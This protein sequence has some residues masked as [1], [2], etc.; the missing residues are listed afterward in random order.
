VVSEDTASQAKYG[1]REYPD[2]GPFI[3]SYGEAQDWCN[4]VT[5][6]YGDLR[7]GYTVTI[8]ANRSLNHMRWCM[9]R[10]VSDLVELIF[11]SSSR[12]GTGLGLNANFYIESVGMTMDSNRILTAAYQFSPAV[13]FQDFW[14]LDLSLLGLNTKVGY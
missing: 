4:L 7:P 11:D 9:Q 2:K 13:G 1:K 12:F 8:A 14:V 3:P 10:E 6:V 5:N